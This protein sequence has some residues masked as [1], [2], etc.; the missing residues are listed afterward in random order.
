[1]SGFPGL[2]PFNRDVLIADLVARAKALLDHPQLRRH[3]LPVIAVVV[4]H[5]GILWILA[6][7]FVVHRP[8]PQGQ[9]IV[10]SLLAPV[11]I[12]KDPAPPTK[13]VD[14]SLPIVPQPLVQTD[15]NT[16]SMMTVQPSSAMAQL[17]APRPDPDHP[18]DAPELPAAAKATSQTAPLILRVLVVE[19]GAVQDA[20]IEKSTGVATLDQ[21]ALE[22]V[23][24][25]WR[26]LP[27][28]IAGRAIQYWTTVVVPLAA[29]A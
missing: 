1:M 12:Q 7:S 4:V 25:H 8:A 9:E 23:K 3:S 6:Y 14:P 24:A 16:P 2:F 19:T 5:L 20:Q 26:Y 17:L 10:I 21:M 22:F 27:A 15:P 29:K 28:T 18:N 11:G 13:L